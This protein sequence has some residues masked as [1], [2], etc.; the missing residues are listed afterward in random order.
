M[1]PQPSNPQATPPTRS[2]RA[3]AIAWVLIAFL[4][5]GATYAYLRGQAN[6]KIVVPVKDEQRQSG[7]FTM[8]GTVSHIDENNKRLNALR[9]GNEDLDA[10]TLSDGSGSTIV[11]RRPAQPTPNEGAR[12][13]VLGALIEQRGLGAKRFV[14]EELTPL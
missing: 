10:F 12:V 4:G 14:I 9:L 7:R 6:A 2:A 1:L 5:A 3:N 8:E 11:N 13:R